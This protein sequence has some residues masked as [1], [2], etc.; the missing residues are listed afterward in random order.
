MD[1][2]W[3]CKLCGKTAKTRQIIKRHAETHIKGVSH[4]CHLCKKS[5]STTHNLKSHISRIHSALVNCNL[6]G[7]AGM[8]KA[9]YS[10]HKKNKHAS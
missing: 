9:N 8:T 7:K 10:C 2:I 3:R 5:F 1:S 4:G 6:C